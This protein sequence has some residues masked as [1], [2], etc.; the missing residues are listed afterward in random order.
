[1]RNAG[2]GSFLGTQSLFAVFAQDDFKL[3]PRLTL[4]LGLRYE[5]WTN[6]V[7][8]DTQAL[9]AISNV[10]GVITFGKPKTDKNNFGPRV[11]LAWDPRGN[12]KTAVRAGFGVSYGWK[13]Q[14]F[15][16]ITLPPQLQSELNEPS[17]CTLTPQPSWC[18]SG[19]GF[20]AGGGLP[21][22]YIAPAT[23]AAARGLTTS[24]IDDTVMPKY[25]NWT[26]AVEHQLYRNATLE[27][28]YLG[29]RGLSLPVQFRRNH[30]SAFDAGIAPLPTFFKT[31]DVPAA[32]TASTPTDA[33]LNA[34]NSNI[35]AP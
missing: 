27:V 5:Y 16:S 7:G 3:N 8:D 25:F 23:Q 24:F 4:N 12:G 20:L 31:S 13:F 11:G 19:T 10:P 2:T 1:L 33:P 28:R 29:T 30:I 17:A 14:N 15:A 6:P 26:L 32:W 18:A 35:Y 21:Q 9:N 34:F 22:T